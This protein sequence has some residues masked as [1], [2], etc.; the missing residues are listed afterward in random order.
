V[1]HP[2]A[3]IAPADYE[4][5][6]GVITSR[7]RELQLPFFSKVNLRNATRLLQQ[8]GYAVTLTPIPT[9]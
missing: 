4:V 9:A 5:A 1:A 6:Y 7:G 2:A 8:F 3:A